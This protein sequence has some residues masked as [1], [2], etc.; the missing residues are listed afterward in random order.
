MCLQE[1]YV[2]ITTSEN[3]G[4]LLPPKDTKKCAEKLPTS[5]VKKKV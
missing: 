1:L 2:K 5:N 3:A 4:Y